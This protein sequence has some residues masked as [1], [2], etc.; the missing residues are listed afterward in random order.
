MPVALTPIQSRFL[1]VAFGQFMRLA[2]GRGMVD[3][4]VC[5]WLLSLGSRWLVAHGVDRESVHAWVEREMRD[6]RIPTPLIASAASR[7]DFGG[8]R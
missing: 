1:Q 3:Q 5:E 2:R 7:N 4:D 8:K 6:T